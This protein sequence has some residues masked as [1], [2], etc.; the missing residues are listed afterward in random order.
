MADEL[1]MPVALQLAQALTAIGHPRIAGAIEGTAEDLIR[2]CTGSILDNVVWPAEAQAR[3][4]VRE[5]KE[6]WDE[7][8]PDKGGTAKLRSLFLAK[9]ERRKLHPEQNVFNTAELEAKY[10]PPDPEWSHKLVHFPSPTGDRV[11]DHRA[12][13]EAMRYQAIRDAL[14]YTEGK[15]MANHKGDRAERNYDEGYWNRAMERLTQAHPEEV[16]YLRAAIARGD[17]DATPPLPEYRPVAAHSLTVDEY[18][19]LAPA[20]PEDPEQKRC[21]ECNGTGRLAGDDYCMCRTGR[22]LRRIEES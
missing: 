2:W 14:Y 6:T 7:G 13:I 1:T 20:I 15:G 17:L 3:W 5:A 21:V 19:R 9:F 22:D 4:L 10:G 12:N 18:R 11:K 8:W 16:R